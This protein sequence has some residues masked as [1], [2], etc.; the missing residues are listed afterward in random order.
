[1]GYENTEEASDAR[2][3]VPHVEPE[4]QNTF[5]VPGFVPPI[6]AG[7][8]GHVPRPEPID[9]EAWERAGKLSPIQVLEPTEAQGLS[10]TLPGGGTLIDIGRWFPMVDQLQ[11]FHALDL[12]TILAHLDS[13]AMA[14]K[15]EL[16]VRQHGHGPRR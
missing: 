6:D 12:R 16:D 1:M 8:D 13:A 7:A 3:N 9:V 4:R 2:F 10:F 14:I 5:R 15:A 11:D